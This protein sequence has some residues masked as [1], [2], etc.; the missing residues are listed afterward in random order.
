MRAGQPSLPKSTISAELRDGF[1]ELLITWPFRDARGGCE[2]APWMSFRNLDSVDYKV[3]H[4]KLHHE[5]SRN[6][7]DE[8]R[9][10]PK[11]WERASRETDRRYGPEY[12]KARQ[13]KEERLPV[14]LERDP[15]FGDGHYEERRKRMDI[16]LHGLERRGR[17]AF[18]RPYKALEEARQI[19]LDRLLPGRGLDRRREFIERR[20]RL[21][22]SLEVC[23][24][25]FRTSYATGFG[26]R[27]HLT[28][29]YP[30]I[31]P[32]LETI[33]AINNLLAQ[34]SKDEHLNF[35]P[36]GRLRRERSGAPSRPELRKAKRDLKAAGVPQDYFDRQQGEMVQPQKELLI[37][38][39]LLPFEK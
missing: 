26:V 6:L 10:G 20:N 18:E 9:W 5:M 12:V 22:R 19:Y 32:S 28:T 34:L 39:G 1:H 16:V 15:E 27:Q 2:K 13:Q 37:C 24:Q 38:C 3:D 33:F 36:E 17:T 29:P 23:L 21:K 25:E 35:T 11:I 8:K 31:A 14:E 30:P 4:L 7:P